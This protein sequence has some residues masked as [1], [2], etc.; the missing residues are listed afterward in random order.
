MII[1][2]ERLQ[3]TGWGFFVL[4]KLNMAKARHQVI[5]RCDVLN[6]SLSTEGTDT[7]TSEA[8][9]RASSLNP[10][11]PN[12]WYLPEYAAFFSDVDYDAPVVRCISDKP[13]F[14]HA[15]ALFVDMNASVS[16]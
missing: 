2:R 11:K 16:L 8:A 9:R 3:F 10:E 6:S 5:T 15:A 13:D 14:L 4:C 12:A 1:P 7:W